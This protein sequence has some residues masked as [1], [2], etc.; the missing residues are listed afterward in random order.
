MSI[1]QDL[2]FH[3]QEIDTLDAAM[4]KLNIVF[5]IQVRLE[6]SSMK[7]K[8]YLQLEKE[9]TN[10]STFALSMAFNCNI[11]FHIHLPVEC[12]EFRRV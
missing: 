12:R 7:V 1:A 2:R 4:K 5:G 8:K 9:T 6:K 10:L 11:L 3:I